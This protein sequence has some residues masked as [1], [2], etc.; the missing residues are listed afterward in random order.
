LGAP[1]TFT[2]NCGDVPGSAVTETCTAVA[3]AGVSEIE[4]RDNWM[5]KGAAC[6]TVRENVTEWLIEPLAPV[7]VTVD[8]ASGA[9][10]AAA[11]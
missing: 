9:F 11:S 7:T 3:D 5:E 2:A 1:D 8:V 10:S 6:R 4:D